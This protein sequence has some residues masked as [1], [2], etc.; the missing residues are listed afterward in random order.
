MDVIIARKSE[1]YCICKNIKHFCNFRGI[2]MDDYKQPTEAELLNM[3]KFEVRGS[4]NDKPIRIIYIPHKSRYS[5]PADLNTILIDDIETIII[6]G[7]QIKKI[8]TSS[9]KTP[10]TVIDGKYLLTNIA[11]RFKV[12]GYKINIVDKDEVEHIMHMYK[13]PNKRCFSAISEKSHE[14]IWLG[15][16]LDD[17]IY[18]EYPTIASCEVSAN[19]K[20]VSKEIPLIE[21]EEET[22]E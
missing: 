17:I 7:I 15:A 6:K 13:I 22:V 1:G 3:N 20:I 19:Y 14:V 10:V 11:K 4:Y 21:E 8:K 12:C 16:K 2:T 5:K 9:L 18:L